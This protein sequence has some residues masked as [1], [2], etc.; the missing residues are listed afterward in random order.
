MFL[1]QVLDNV[2]YVFAIVMLIGGILILISVIAIVML[3][4]M[5]AIVNGVKEDKENN[6]L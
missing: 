5:S 1:L 4:T 6:N 2:F 3:A